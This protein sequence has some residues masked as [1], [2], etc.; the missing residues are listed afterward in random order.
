ME[1]VLISG[2]TGLVGRHLTKTLLER[3][4]GVALLSR[5]LNHTGSVKAYFWDPEKSQIDSAAILAADYIIHL[6]GA[7]IGDRRWT[8]KRKQII[9]DS[10]I[11]SAE[12]LFNSLTCNNHKIKAYISASAVGYYGAVTSDR[13]FSE[14]DLPAEDFTGFICRNWEMEA[15]RFEKTGIRTVVIRT[16]IVLSNHGGALQKIALPVRLGIGSAL[17]SGE[18]YIPWIHIEDLCNIYIKAIEETGFKGP[19]NAVAPDNQTNRSLTRS[20][21]AVMK[22]PFWFPDIPAFA[23]KILF[24]KMSEILLQGSRVSS[25]KIREAGYVFKFPSLEGALNDLFRTN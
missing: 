6:A 12:L 3:G 16:G 14:N 17:G 23:L 2:G 4:Y 22:K 11:N 10:R 18:Q 5:K 24:G 19:Y 20:L 8:E 1:T 7:G 9:L 21:A 15:D 25:E 13:I